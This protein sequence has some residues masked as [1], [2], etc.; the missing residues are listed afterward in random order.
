MRIMFSGI[1][2]NWINLSSFSYAINNDGL[3]M[4]GK[5]KKLDF[6]KNFISLRNILWCE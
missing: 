3:E 6:S 1:Q 5:R 4:V 2:P